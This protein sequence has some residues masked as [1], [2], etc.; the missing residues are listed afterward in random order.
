MAI[1]DILFAEGMKD[2]RL[3]E[4]GEGLQGPGQST[5]ES[6]L[7]GVNVGDPGRSASRGV[8]QEQGLVPGIGGADD[9]WGGLDM[10]SIG[11][12]LG[13]S[14]DRAQTM[15]DQGHLGWAQEE[16]NVQKSSGI[17]YAPSE[18]AKYGRD[19][20]VNFANYTPYN[21]RTG[22]GSEFV[23]SGSG[24]DAYRGGGGIQPQYDLT[25]YNQA[26]AE[27]RKVSDARQARSQKMNDSPQEE[28]F[29]NLLNLSPEELQQI[30]FSDSASM[31]NLASKS[32]FYSGSKDANRSK[33]GLIQDTDDESGL[34]KAMKVGVP[35][36]VKALTSFI[37]PV[38]GA[39]MSGFMTKAQGGSWG[40]AA[41]GAG[42]GLATS[43]AGGAL[44]GGF[45]AAQAGTSIGEGALQGAT[46]TLTSAGLRSA[47]DTLM[48]GTQSAPGTGTMSV[49]N[50]DGTTTDFLLSNE[51]AKIGSSGGVTEVPQGT[52]F[53][54]EAAAKFG[55][56][57]FANVIG[58]PINQVP[59]GKDLATSV[60]GDMISAFQSIFSP[61]AAAKGKGLYAEGTGLVP[62]YLGAGDET[63]AGAFNTYSEQQ[64]GG[65]GAR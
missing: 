1:Q 56:P 7:S 63:G 23:S 35:M 13:L 53:T 40:D 29:N 48:G 18:V 45:G 33:V 14:R 39:A 44:S 26:Q 61:E 58:A 60:G 15:L 49:Q 38:A 17:Q 20:S 8:A 30:D 27:A 16:P 65:I 51:G 11:E 41:T 50:P 3:L 12:A 10:L 25:A 52:Q 34:S 19:A 37:N 55:N 31:Q 9:K 5:L 4:G 36:A 57:D 22:E 2:R 6:M 64:V 21:E 42:M 59:T 32:L 24:R 47:G 43:L 54:P 62:G 46:D 28:I